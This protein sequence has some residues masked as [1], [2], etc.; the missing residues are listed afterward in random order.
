[1]INW[2]NAA[3]RSSK[4]RIG[5]GNLKVIGDPDKRSLRTVMGVKAL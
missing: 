2:S 1:M 4:L 5:F 3:V